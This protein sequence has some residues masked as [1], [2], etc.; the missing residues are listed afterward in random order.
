MAAA[1]ASV[2][3]YMWVKVACWLASG[4]RLQYDGVAGIYCSLSVLRDSLLRCTRRPS[5]V[6]N[7]YP[8]GQIVGWNCTAV[9]GSQ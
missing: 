1:S 3:T 5:A 9:A 2:T 4:K 8:T 7:V 6:N